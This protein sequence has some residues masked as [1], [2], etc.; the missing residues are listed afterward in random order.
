QLTPDGQFINEDITINTSDEPDHQHLCDR[1]QRFFLKAIQQDLDLNDHLNDAVNS[2]RIVLA[3]DDS[4][5]TGKV[6]DL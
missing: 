4:V 5:R 6:I 3:A 1:E 2:L